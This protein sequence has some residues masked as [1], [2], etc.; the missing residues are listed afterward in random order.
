MP[1]AWKSSE[2]L[3]SGPYSPPRTRAHDRA[4]KRRGRNR[5]RRRRNLSHLRC[6]S[7]G[8]PRHQRCLSRG[9]H[10]RPRLSRSRLL[11]SHSRKRPSQSRQS[12]RPQAATRRQNPSPSPFVVVKE[13]P[14]YSED[15]PQ[16]QADPPAAA[17]WVFV[18]DLLDQTA[19]NPDQ[20]LRRAQQRR[21]PQPQRTSGWTQAGSPADSTLGSTI[22]S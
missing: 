8:H 22:E 2:S 5:Q 12:R 21:R 3:P 14:D 4:T 10:H 9:P 15:E 11:Q 18:R 20:R 17:S 6:Q 1:F 13:E 7:P 19:V 16:P